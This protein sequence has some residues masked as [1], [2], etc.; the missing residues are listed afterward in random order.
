MVAARS[1]AERWE[2]VAVE[3]DGVASLNQ[4]RVAGSFEEGVVG[5]DVA[6]TLQAGKKRKV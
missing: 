3:H 1:R 4:N 6:S 5:C 2:I